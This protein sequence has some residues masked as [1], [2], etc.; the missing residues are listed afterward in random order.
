MSA[1]FAPACQ[2][3]VYGVS[4]GDAALTLSARRFTSRS[5]AARMNSLTECSPR[6]RSIEKAIVIIDDKTKECGKLLNL[7][8][9][10]VYEYY[11]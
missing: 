10:Q 8:R 6:R 2:Y 9:E 3:V 11:T 5:I 4:T 7:I 1:L